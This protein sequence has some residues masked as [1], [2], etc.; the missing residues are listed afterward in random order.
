MAKLPQNTNPKSQTVDEAQIREISS[1]KILKGIGFVGD[2]FTKVSANDSSMNTSYE[3]ESKKTTKILNDIK[4]VLNNINQAL[5]KFLDKELRESVVQKDL[6]ETK[7]EDFQTEYVKEDADKTL[8]L[9]SLDKLEIKEAKIHNLKIEKIEIENIEGQLQNES[10]Q[11][12][13]KGVPNLGNSK[14]KAIG[15]MVEEGGLLSSLKNIA[16]AV[17]SGEGLTALVGGGLV[18]SSLMG[19]SGMF[20]VENYADYNKELKS[21]SGDSEKLMKSTYDAFSKAGFSDKQ[22]KALVAEVGREGSFNP[23]NVFGT[24]TDPA[25]Q[26][27]NIG[28]FSW[29]KERGQQLFKELKEKGL[30]DS[31]GKISRTQESLDAMAQFTKKEMESNPKYYSVNK[32]FLQNPDIDPEKASEI[33]GKKY[34]A[35]R[36]SDP[37]FA[38]GHARRKAYGKK[39]EEMVPSKEESILDR[40][41]NYIEPKAEAVEHFMKDERPTSEKLEEMATNSLKEEISDFTNRRKED[42]IRASEAVIDGFKELNDPNLL[43]LEK[44]TETKKTEKAEPVAEEVKTQPKTETV[45]KEPTTGPVTE[46]KIETSPKKVK[47]NLPKFSPKRKEEEEEEEEINEPIKTER[48]SLTST[49]EYVPTAAIQ[50][51]QGLAIDS[52]SRNISESKQEMATQPQQP[53]IVNQGG[54]GGGQSRS[55]TQK[56]PSNE[57]PMGIEVGARSNEPTLLKAQYNSVRPL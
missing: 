33:L 6:V 4:N 54:G 12:Y 51:P 27:T 34:V 22:A 42:V 9:F 28:M 24:H 1:E 18:G 30:V 15:K 23:E 39:I 47:I 14:T 5:V 11:R 35:W 32:D 20:S 38:S 3:K 56:T 21:I 25:N 13:T 2:K 49:S 57:S 41:K 16:G 55:K 44:N 10:E 52:I 8:K 29:Q 48:S 37:E 50:I 53:I 43:K 7:L 19:R 36:Y 46:Q 45:H 26:E 40:A 31:N 17:M